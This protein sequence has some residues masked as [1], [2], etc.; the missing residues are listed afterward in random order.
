MEKENCGSINKTS[1]GPRGVTVILMGDW[2]R[3]SQAGHM[4]PRR[5]VGDQGV[6]PWPITPT[7]EQPCCSWKWPRCFQRWL[8]P[9]SGVCTP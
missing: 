3:L 9:T 1:A 2:C 4:P 6:P 5:P 7:S 8:R